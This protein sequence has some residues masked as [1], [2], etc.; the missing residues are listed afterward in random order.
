VCFS[1]LTLSLALLMGAMLSGCAPLA[2]PV[3]RAT[4][5][6]TATP[7]SAAIVTPAA[8]APAATPMS[9]IEA[10][11]AAR[12]RR[13][14]GSLG[15]RVQASYDPEKKAATITVTVAGG[16]PFTDQQIAAAHN[17][18]ELITY[19]VMEAAWSSGEPLSAVTA[20]V[21]GPIQ[22]EYA[23]IVPDW[24]GVAVVKVATARGITWPSA[25]P[26]EVWSR[27]D[28]AMLRASFDVFD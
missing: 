11:L 2:G 7:T 27:Y 26:Y 16:I 14:I 3:S 10:D 17:R 4:T 1:L 19:W 25:N 13:A 5:A 28:Q 24:Y 23:D 12:A 9:P 18:V 6:T 22:D 15:Q 21:L 20:I 8:T